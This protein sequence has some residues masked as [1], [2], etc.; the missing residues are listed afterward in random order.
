MGASAW[1]NQISATGA[2]ELANDGSWAMRSSRYET[3]ATQANRMVVATLGP[4]PSP[5]KLSNN[6]A[7]AAIP[8]ASVVVIDDA[9]VVR[10]GQAAQQPACD[11][12]DRS[13]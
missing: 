1:R 4:R 8:D 11:E 7:R 3:S 9:V 12:R 13:E 6:E 5:T 2:T 10:L